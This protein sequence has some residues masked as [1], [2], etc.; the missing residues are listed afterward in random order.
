MPFIW[1]WNKIKSLFGGKPKQ[2]AAPPAAPPAA[3][4]DE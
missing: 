2:G 1:I 3:P 4:L